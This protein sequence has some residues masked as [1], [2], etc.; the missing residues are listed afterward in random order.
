MA[1]SRAVARVQACRRCA[2]MAQGGCEPQPDPPNHHDQPAAR[3][4]R[5][6]RRRHR[7][8]LGISLIGGCDTR[9]LVGGSKTLAD[10][11]IGLVF[12]ESTSRIDSRHVAG[13]PRHAHRLKVYYATM[14]TLFTIG[15][16]QAT[17]EAILDELRR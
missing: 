2:G 11:E 16:E 8:L 9:G 12:N 13:P 15:Y 1:V 17:S 5:G 14:S 4:H 6:R 10:F 7:P 3:P